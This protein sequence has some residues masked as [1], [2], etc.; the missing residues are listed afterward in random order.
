MTENTAPQTSAITGDILPISKYLYD[1]FARKHPTPAV[2]FVFGIT[3]QIARVYF[4]P[5]GE[6]VADSRMDDDGIIHMEYPIE[7]LSDVVILLNNPTQRYLVYAEG[8]TNAR[9]SWNP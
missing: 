8:G 2:M 6:P 4:Q 7:A 3:R 5:T 1:L 9:F